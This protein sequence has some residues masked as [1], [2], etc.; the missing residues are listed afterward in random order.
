MSFQNDLCALRGDMVNMSPYLS[1]C[2]LTLARP[3]PLATE[4]TERTEPPQGL[5]QTTLVLIF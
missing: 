3:R 1:R 2:Q 4:I 5:T